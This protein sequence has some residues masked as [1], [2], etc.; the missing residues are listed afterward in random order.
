MIAPDEQEQEI[1]QNQAELN[2]E[3]TATDDPDEI[4]CI[5]EEIEDLAQE[6]EDIAD[7]EETA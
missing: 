5:V 1:A 7:L 6:A 2:E 4:A 3:L